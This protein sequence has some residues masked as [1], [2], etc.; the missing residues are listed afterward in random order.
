[1]NHIHEQD[2]DLVGRIAVGDN[3][4]FR[5][6]HSRYARNIDGFVRVRANNRDDAEDIVQDTWGALWEKAKT[7]DKN[8]GAVST[9]LRMLG[10]TAIA[11]FYRRNAQR[12]SKAAVP[13][14]GESSENL[15]SM[16][17]SGPEGMNRVLEDLMLKLVFGGS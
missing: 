7:Y 16:L 15:L 12:V 14:E 1:M 10:V 2:G 8:R 17:R 3:D 4:A 5:E 6:I 11:N 9:F 13:V